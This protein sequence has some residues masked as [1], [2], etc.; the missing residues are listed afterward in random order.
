MESLNLFIRGV[1]IHGT[2]EDVEISD[3]DLEG[4]SVFVERLQQGMSVLEAVQGI[5]ADVYIEAE[6]EFSEDEDDDIED[7]YFMYGDEEEDE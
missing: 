3:M 4:L 5:D 2:L 6:E 7:S 1:D